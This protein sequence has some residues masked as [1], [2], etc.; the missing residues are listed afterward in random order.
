MGNSKRHS[1]KPIFHRKYKNSS[2]ACE[3]IHSSMT[4][5]VYSGSGIVPSQHPLNKDLGL[6]YASCHNC[7]S[8]NIMVI[9]TKRCVHPFSGDEYYDYEILCQDCHKFTQVSHAD[10]D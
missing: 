8:K 7:D 5:L 6:S 1:S 2:Q 4:E 9:Y 3:E 10:N